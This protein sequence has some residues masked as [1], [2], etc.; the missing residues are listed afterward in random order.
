MGA[1]PDGIVTFLLTDVE[2]STVLWEHAPEAMRQALARHDAIFERLIPAHGGT[3]I[4][5]RGEG[6]S[7]FAVFAAAPDA[8]AAALAVQRAFAAEAW[9]TPWPLAV[10]I[11]LHAGLAELRDGDYYGAEVNRCARLRGIGH[12][13]QVL[14][15]EAAAAL[16]RDGLPPD[17]RLLDRGEHRLRDVSRPE[18]VFEL[19]A[20]D[21]AQEFPPLSSLAVRPHNLPT[22]ATVLLGRQRDVDE[23]RRLLLQPETRLVTLTGPGGTGKTRLAIQIAAELLD[24]LEHG[25]FFVELAPVRD[26]TLVPSAI[27][28]VL[29]LRDMGGRSIVESLNEY[30][31]RR[32]LLLVLDN[33]EQIVTAAPAVADLLAV[34]PGLRVLVTSREPLRLRGEREYAVPPLALPDPQ[35]RTAPD[36]LSGYAAAA[37]FVERAAAIRADFAVTAENAPAITE[38]CHRLDGLPLAIELAAARVRLLTPEAMLARLDRRLPL[39][40]QGA[41][42]LPA[43]QRTLRDAI[44]WSY[45]LLTPT[46]QALFRRLAIFVGGCTLETAEAVAVAEVGDR[47]WALDPVEALDDVESLIAKSLLRQI[48]GRDGTPRITMLETIREYGVEELRRAGEL[49][50]LRRWHASYFLA[51]AEQAVPRFQGPE[52]RV[53]L[54][55]IESDH[56]NLRAALEWSLSDDRQSDAAL[57]LSGALAWFW[58]ARCYFPEGRRWLGRALTESPPHPDARITALYGA[59]WMAHI[60]RD[61]IAARQHLEAAIDLARERN[62]RWGLAWALQVLGRVAYFDNDTEQARDLGEQSLR[63]ARQID[64][65]WLIAWALHLLGLAAHIGTDY[66]AALAYYDEALAIRRRLGYLEGIGICFNIMGVTAY[67]RGDLAASLEHIRAAARTLREVGVDWTIHN[68]LAMFATLA[69]A[70]GQPRL[71]ARLAGATTA[72]GESLDVRPIPIIE[73]VLAPALAAARATLGQTEYESAIA[74]GGA[75]SLDEA[76]AEAQAIS[77]LP[78]ATPAVARSAGPAR[79]RSSEPSG[80]SPREIEVLR[81]LAAGHT[82][83]E[84]AEALVLSVRTVE[85]HIT[86][87]YEKIGARGRADAAAFALKH[88]LL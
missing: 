77:A 55:R 59:G 75:L 28:Q 76:V 70:L 47:R 3:P 71:A 43:R 84:V 23:V 29:G 26:P 18:R 27:A 74:D 7:R 33:F 86:H 73:E 49:H 22:Q 46:E 32:S 81:L 66:H 69:A 83:K 45:D 6:D 53:W 41:Q 78:V 1:L 52:Q 17:A 64:D 10:R 15:S 20:N 25:V 65:D 35:R 31:R 9:P 12:G 68:T 8:T 54:D 19:V 40:T 51:L 44:A 21:L 79:D 80:L 56:A 39:L 42:D 82:S 88:G 60:H 63:T 30:L 36:E 58:T 38:I 50:S 14:L 37:L 67:R 11:G 34:S 24:D 62:D 85:R 16:A 48:G 4:R 87:V 72:F 61:G 5:P 2:G 13:G 57:R